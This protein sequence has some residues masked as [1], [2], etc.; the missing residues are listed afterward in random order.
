VPELVQGDPVEAADSPRRKAPTATAAQAS[1]AWS[2]SARGLK[3]A[4]T[5]GTEEK[6]DELVADARKRFRSAL[7]DA[8]KAGSPK[9]D[10]GKPRC[11][12]APPLLEKIG[13]S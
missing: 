4:A 7:R 10:P 5:R 9:T 1:S 2:A 12:S 13:V 3:G 11:Q 8:H 6:A